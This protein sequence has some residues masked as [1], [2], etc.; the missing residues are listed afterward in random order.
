MKEIISGLSVFFKREQINKRGKSILFLV[1]NRLVKKAIM[2][3]KEWFINFIKDSTF[4]N[5][6]EMFM[7]SLFPIKF[8]D[9]ILM[10]YKPARLLDVGCGQG[11]SLKYFLSNGVEGVGVENSSL[12][13]QKFGITDKIVNFNL[14]NEL[15]LKKDFDRVWC[16]ELIEHI[17]PK[18]E[19]NIF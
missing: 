9:A 19:K 13:I 8:L 14:N 15:D 6:N 11:V 17:H 18:F 3:Y 4:N 12:A 1:L 10:H 16:F 2:H 7:Y 5:E